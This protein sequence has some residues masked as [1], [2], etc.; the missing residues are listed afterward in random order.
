M[1]ALLLNSSY[2]VISFIT[3]RR[4]IKLYVNDKVEILSE[5][6]EIIRWVEGEM[7]FPA[8]LRLKYAVPWRHRKMRCSRKS[9]LRR[10]LYTCQYCYTVFAPS[11]LTWDHVIPRCKGGRSTWENV[12]CSCSPCNRLKGDRTPE[13]ANMKLL[14]KPIAPNRNVFNE[15]KLMNLKHADWEF[16]MG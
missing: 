8:T 3:F 1:K 5:W 16:Y 11:K 6:N 2:E 15:Y 13:E 9:V 7:A 12:V 14:R 10:D 4:A